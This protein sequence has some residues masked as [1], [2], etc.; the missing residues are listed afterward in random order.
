MHTAH[1][2]YRSAGFV[3]RGPYDESEIPP[4]FWPYWIFMELAL[5][6]AERVN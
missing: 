2:L 1:A 5:D 6:H 4:E 3:E